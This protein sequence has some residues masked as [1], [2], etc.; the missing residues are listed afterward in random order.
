M[1][2]YVLLLFKKKIP[3][4]QN[5]MS[6]TREKKAKEAKK[7][8]KK[9]EKGEINKLRLVYATNYK[10][11]IYIFHAYITKCSLILNITTI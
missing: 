3:P 1:L 2:L 10:T 5:L 11:R 9:H 6:I 8:R 4:S 7:K